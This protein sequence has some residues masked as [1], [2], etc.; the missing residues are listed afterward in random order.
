[1]KNKKVHKN[2]KIEDVFALVKTCGTSSNYRTEN[3]QIIAIGIMGWNSFDEMN[4]VISLNDIG[5]DNDYHS[6]IILPIKRFNEFRRIFN[7]DEGCDS[8]Q[9][10]MEDYVGKYVRLVWEEI[11]I[12]QRH[13]LD[14]GP[15]TLYAIKHIIHDEKPYTFYINPDNKKK[16]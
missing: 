11:P 13:E 16:A 2:P 3:R 8:Y 12:E 6:Q 4:F 14:D 1:M 10:H 5:Y 7:L 15:E 9:W